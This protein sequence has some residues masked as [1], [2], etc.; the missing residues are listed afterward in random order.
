MK[1]KWIL[2]MIFSTVYA[3]DLFCSNYTFKN[4][5]AKE[6][7]RCGYVEVGELH[8]N[9]C[10]KG[11]ICEPLRFGLESVCVKD[12]RKRLHGENCT[13][14]E[15]CESNNCPKEV[16]VGFNEGAKCTNTVQCAAE[17]YCNETCK[18]AVENG[19]IC[20]TTIRCKSNAFCHIPQGKVNG[21]CYT[22]ASIDEGKE[23]PAPAAC[24]TYHT[25]KNGT[26]M[27]GYMLPS[28]RTVCNG[29]CTYGYN[30]TKV[31]ASCT[32]GRKND[33]KLCPLG[34]ADLKLDAVILRLMS[35]L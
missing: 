17:L 35:S 30:G 19:E 22:Y 26:C 24:K 11:L 10:E 16:C 23:A 31:K 32:C 4:I 27:K 9:E 15:E 2:L 18:P 7:E 25:A 21:I 1:T 5:T 34:V 20:N 6:N 8:F 3:A 13:K 28:R 12:T 33:A 14:N 29:H